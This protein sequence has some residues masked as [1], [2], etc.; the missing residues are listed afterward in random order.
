MM[1]QKQ[2]IVSKKVSSLLVL[3]VVKENLFFA[4]L[5]LVAVAV[6]VP[7]SPGMPWEGLDP[8][9]VYGMNEAVAQGMSFGK[10]IVFTFGPY[11][12][13]YTKNYHPATDQLMIW[14][15]LYLAI[16]FAIAAY[17]NFRLIGW[18]FRLALLAVLSVVMYSRDA[19][20]FFY[21]MLVG[22]QIYHWAALFD[23]K[24]DAG[25]A[26]IMLKVALFAPFGLLP[27]VK[28]SFLIA[29]TAI[30]VLSIALLAR[31]GQWKLCL[32][33]GAI[34][35][36]S[37][38]IFWLLSG[39]PLVGLANY[40]T[41]L[42]PI[43][44][45]YTEAM[46]TNGNPRE[47][48][49]YTAAVAALVV[50]LLREVQG[51]AYDKAIVALV[52][53]CIHFLAFKAGFVRHDGHAGCAGTMILLGAL[54]AGTLLSARRSLALLLVCLVAWIYID[55]AHVKT[56][57]HSIK[58]NI[59]NTYASAWTGLKQRIKDPE[60]LTRSFEARVNEL[61]KR[62]AIPKLNG[63]VDIYSYDQS[64][65]IASGNK[66]NPRPIFQSYSAYSSKLAELNK[67]HLVSKNRPDNIIFNVQPIDGKL[68]SLEDGASWPV[69][70]SNYEPTSFSG[71]YLFLKQRSA[72]SLAYEAAK[73]QGGGMYSLGEQINLPESDV[74]LFVKV[75]IRKSFIGAI[76]NTLFKPSQLVIKL[77]MQN[78]TTRDYRIVAGMSES[79]FVVSPLIEN[80]EEL[81]LLFSGASYLNEKKV[82]S[83]EIVAPH[84]SLLWKSSFEISFYRLDFQPLPDFFEQM[85]Y[86]K[87]R[88]EVLNKVISAQRC[89]GSIDYA[90][91]VSS[92]SH[93][94]KATSSLNINGW[95]AASVE[96]AEVP[97]KV[98][99]VL[100][101]NEG[102]RYF[103]DAKRTQ[104]LDVGTHFNKL[105]LNSSGYE[106]KANVSDLVGQY[107]LGLAYLKGNEIF[108]CPQ[109]NIPVKLNQD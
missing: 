27:L 43:I 2:N 94:I 6:F 90:N 61:N 104:R 66:W 79:G 46:A 20:F 102:K 89:D 65:L 29:C 58:E 49:L 13:I 42:L 51:S 106:A 101:S 62:G 50:L 31:R 3:K 103:L 76:L 78:G 75:N 28:G 32:I 95:L 23:S 107:H 77:T 15:S 56:S 17:L 87:P 57:T 59:K 99:L 68:P 9:W 1:N 98:Y 63:S 108:V 80:T 44:S 21:P 39:Q 34:P 18:P 24:R 40:F 12:S 96:N 60:A 38:V 26:E 25:I 36:V 67:M 37:L 41:G 8:S 54:L 5:L 84:L 11:A 85:G 91:G 86:L 33:I 69:L 93:L 4:A 45:G 92:M 82:K 70:L 7:F 109:F 14:G 35:L 16:S 100:S 52:F 19:P 88:V 30:S 55:A 73:K 48:I 22:V 71:G 53:S 83:M 97:D 10:D 47:Y 72:S 74:P 64:Y 105:A 81:G